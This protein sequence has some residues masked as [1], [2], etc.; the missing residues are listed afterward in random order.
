M[1]RKDATSRE[2]GNGLQRPFQPVEEIPWFRE[3]PVT[4]TIATENE[5]SSQ[6]RLVA[7]LTYLQRMSHSQKRKIPP[8]V[9]LLIQIRQSQR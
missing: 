6:S 5:S 3:Q 1:E 2:W 9:G 8:A 7:Y 4:S